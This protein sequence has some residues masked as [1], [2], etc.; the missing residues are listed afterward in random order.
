MKRWNRD[1]FGNVKKLIKKMRLL[2][3]VEKE[4]MSSS[5][6]HQTRELKREITE[7]IDEQDAVSKI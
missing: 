4:A 7:L 5:M 3:E 1:H 2:V 6:N